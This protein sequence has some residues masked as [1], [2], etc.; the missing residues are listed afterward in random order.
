MADKDDDAEKS[1]EPTPQKLEDRRRKGEIA[2]SADL[3]TAAAY[4]GFLLAGLAIGTDSLITIGSSLMVMFD[5][6]VSLS[7]LLFEGSAASALVG[8]MA[9]VVLALLGWYVIPAGLA[10]LS[11]FGQRSFIFSP[12]KLKPKANRLN[13]IENAKKKF[14]LSGFFEFAKSFVKLLLYSAVLGVYLVHR[15]DNMAGTLYAS[16]HLAGAL[17]GR[18]L[19]EFMFIILLI[20]L[21]IGVIDYLWQRHDFLRR[22]RMSHREVTEEHKRHEGDPHLKQKRRQRG[23]EIASTQMMADVPDADVI[24]VNPTHYAVALKWSRVAGS[25]PVCV[26]KGVD[27]IAQAIRTVAEENNV[28]IRHDP[29]TARALYASTALGDEIDPDHYHAVAASIRFAQ[30]MRDRARYFG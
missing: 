19:I 28:P 22:N 8:L 3:T 21:F 12:E 9:T 2:R 6:S 29:P 23:A 18:L 26:A 17:L 20:A 15:F 7:D 30:A 13:P 14:G 4:G 5:Q 27:H 16:P 24:V 11:V 10:M 25:A 1:H